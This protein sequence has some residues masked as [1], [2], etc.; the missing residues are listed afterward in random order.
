MEE[1]KPETQLIKALTVSE[2]TGQSIPQ[3]YRL[4]RLGQFPRRIHR[5]RSSFWIRHEVIAWNEQQV[6]SD[7]KG[8]KPQAAAQ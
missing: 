1:K 5:G 8:R 3:I 6:E 4:E 7:R 2:L